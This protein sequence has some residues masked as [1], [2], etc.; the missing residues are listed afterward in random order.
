MS[1]SFCSPYWTWQEAQSWT[2]LPMGDLTPGQGSL[3]QQPHCLVFT[4]FIS[5]NLFPLMSSP[6]PSYPFCPKPACFH[7]FLNS[8]VHCSNFHPSFSSNYITHPDACSALI[9]NSFLPHS[10]WFTVQ[11]RGWCLHWDPTPAQFITSGQRTRNISPSLDAMLLLKY[12]NVPL[13][14]KFKHAYRHR[15]ASHS[16]SIF[17]IL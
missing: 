5:P 3:I 4:S 6:M 9:P 7:P 16:K 17:H 13:V 2:A 15:Y 10:G 14:L 8:N 1:T 11:S 12:E